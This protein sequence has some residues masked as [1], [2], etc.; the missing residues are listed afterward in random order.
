M[1]STPNPEP[2]SVDIITL[3]G[4]EYLINWKRLTRGASFFMPTTATPKQAEDALA[5]AA[6]E[7]NMEFAVRARCEYGRYGVRVWR[8]Y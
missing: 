3:N 8:V 6:K 4:S 5:Y 2:T 1:Q 7:L